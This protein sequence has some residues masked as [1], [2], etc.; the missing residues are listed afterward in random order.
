MNT[1]KKAL[2]Q[3][4]QPVDIAALAVF[5]MLFGAM[6]FGGTLRFMSNGW[7]ETLYVQPDFH[8]KFWGFAWV[9]V[10]NETG[11]YLLYSGI[12]LSAALIAIGAFYRVAIIVFFCLFAYA[13]LMDVTYYLNHYYFV[14]LLALILCF[15]SPHKAWSFD[16]WRKPALR[17]KHLP[18]WQLWWL[19]F[20]V[21][22][23]YFYAGLAKFETDWLLHAQP[24][25]I[26]L[27]PLGGMPVLGPLLELPWVHF[28]FSWFAFVF[29]TS[30]VAFLLM[31]KTRV[32]A[33]LVVL[34]F[35]LFTHLF[36]N[37]GLFPLIMVLAA[38][39]FFDPDWP[40]RWI[41][42][43]SSWHRRAASVPGT[44]LV[45]R[46]ASPYRLST[47]PTLSILA[48]C[49][50]QFLMPLRHWYYPGTV[51]WNEQ[52]MRFSWRVMLRE[53]SGALQYRVVRSDGT[54]HIVTPGEYLNELQFREMVGQPDLILQLA[55][56][57]RDDFNADGV[58]PVKVFAD[59]TV[60]L[61]AR[62]AANLIK[63]DAD[64]AQV[65]DGMAI[66]SWITLAP[67]QSPPLQQTLKLA[68]G[69]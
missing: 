11:L 16:A 64:L 69:Q 55:H 63:P 68:G 43:L 2:G 4:A 1:L 38:S 57:I 34:V 8:F 42:Y 61:N 9:Q 22:L 62:P 41:N 15:L 18:A 13:E 31:R 49:L 14:C 6:M 12:A 46:G 45:V 59:A 58:G 30:I 10:P 24:L 35:H 44:A 7:V 51:L 5:R 25:N 50:F 19:R 17:S 52:G 32:Y 67:Q 53:K 66:G 56:R 54:T 65:E 21:A 28:A 48:F 29:D 39:L 3:L 40:R 27:P 37:I 20:Q 26:W 33:F 47:L 60:S 23:L 36:F